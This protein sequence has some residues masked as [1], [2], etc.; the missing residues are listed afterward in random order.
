MN[1]RRSIAR[2]AMSA[3]LR[4]R[5]A[6]GYG[7]EEPLCAYD[8]AERLGI[9]V[10]FMDLPSM[11]GVYAP[12]SPPTIIVSSLRPSGRR[13]YT[14]AHELGH[15]DHGDGL[16]IDELLEHS[17]RARFDPKEF[18]AD[19]FAG[20]LLM[21]KLAVSKA[22]ATRGWCIEEPS[23][24]QISMVAGCFGVGYT[25]LIH[26]LRSALLLL[27]DRQARSLLKVPPRRA[28]SLLLGWETQND[29]VVVDD[30]WTGRPIDVEVGNHILVRGHTEFVGSCLQPFTEVKQ[31]ALFLAARPGIGR[32]GNGA[33][34]SAF[35]R[36]SR[37][38][39]VG[40]ALYRHWEELADE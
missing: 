22:F 11:E 17:D 39:Y 35:V 27:P 34:W 15:H 14:C 19:C 36:V 29:V 16:E 37:R 9:E 6:A 2:K 21:P 7:L 8:L 24:E 31:G 10:R 3:A 38:N 5:L 23:P 20:A 26:H 4:T 33:G 25:T 13:A 18:S 30:H 1:D 12:G 40:R 28:Q 32:L